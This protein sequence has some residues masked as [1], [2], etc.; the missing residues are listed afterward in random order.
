MTQ[1]EQNERIGTR[2]GI[3]AL[4]TVTGALMLTALA[5][6]G[7]APLVNTALDDAR[8][9][10]RNAADDPAVARAGELDLRRAQQALQ[11]GS[12]ALRDGADPVV[13][14]H[15]AYVAKRRTEAAIESNRIAQSEKAVA[16]A[17]RTR[18]AMVIES[19][20]REAEAARRLAEQRL[21]TAE[22]SQQQ[23]A[24]AQQHAR[25]LERQLAALKARQTDRGM[26]LTLGD[27]LF[28][29]GRAQLK[30]GAAR[31]LNQLA[32]FLRENPE[33]TVQIE[34]YTD[35]V[36]SSALNQTLSDDRASAV[37][38]ALMDRGIAITRIAA[39][40]LGEADPVA[41]NR[42]AAGRQRN[43]RVEVI[44]SNEQRQ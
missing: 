32:T 40:G 34:G 8:T 16:N 19:R 39:R 36:G 30:P 33:R 17:T 21:S 7:S 41:T 24:S 20:T 27:V 2:T 37:K 26:V 28:D 9:S 29:T 43:R 11:K 25:M 5:A 18:D 23:A 3:R 42:T 10:Y 38:S 13:V 22:Q 44:I 1:S 31:T 4:A 6:C 14:D 35:S 12:D 15:Y